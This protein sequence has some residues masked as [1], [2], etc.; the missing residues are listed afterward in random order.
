MNLDELRTLLRQDPEYV[1]A[2]R[3]MM[4]SLDFA[5]DM[6][7][8]RIDQKMTQQQLADKTGILLYVIAKIETADGNP[9]INMMRRIADA[10]GGQLVVHIDAREMLHGK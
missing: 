7:R 10:L 6:L 1:K 5:N 8:L 4:P 9:T 2:E 3:D